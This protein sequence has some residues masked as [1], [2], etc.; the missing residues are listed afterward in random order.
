MKMQNIYNIS[1]GRSFWI[2]NTGPLGC[3]PYI[4][5]AFPSAE[6]DEFG[7]A[8]PYN[9][10]A[11]HFNYMLKQAIV[12]LRKDF[13]LAA[14]TYVDIYSVKYSLFTDP[15]KY[16]KINIKKKKIL[17]PFLQKSIYNCTLIIVF[18][19]CCIRI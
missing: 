4:L 16:G 13:P 14:I 3:L 2:H 19:N 12:Q 9:Q 18:I 1:G 7:C 5:T 10:I 6:R 17:I 11:Q 8:K 15:H